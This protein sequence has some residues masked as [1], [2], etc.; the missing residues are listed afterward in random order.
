MLYTTPLGSTV[1]ALSDLLISLLIVAGGLAVAYLVH[2][3]FTWL[4]EKARTSDT[5]LDGLI[6]KILG[7]PL[8]VLVATFPVLYALKRIPAI[9]R[10][11]RR[12]E[13]AETALLVLIGTWLLSNLVQKIIH[14]YGM[15]FAQKTRTTVDERMIH[16]LDL[17]AVYVIWILGG[18]VALRTLGIKV[19][20]FLASMGIAG[21][22]VALAA[23]TVLS[24][25]L[26]GITLTA[27]PYLN[28]GDRIEVNEYIGDVIDI[29]LYKTTI[30]TRENKIVSI[31]NNVLVEE[32]V[33]NH[34]LPE[35]RTRLSL[36]FGVSYDADLNDLTDVVLNVLDEEDRIQADPEPEV[37]LTAFGDS[38]L[39]FEI[40]VWIDSPRGRRTV[41]DFV[42]R[43]LYHQFDEHGIEIPYPQRVVHQ[44]SRDA[45][46]E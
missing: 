10:R 39:Q 7:P 31:P 28:M 29:N 11:F 35:S 44:R 46:Q 24:N 30:R 27:D 14:H 40:Q 37:N 1:V 6:L 21:L 8:S 32:V 43:S 36:P 33:I 9:Q 15:P 2:R 18:L 4:G 19:T 16:I 20:A 41:R 25:M 42:Y 26:G 23:K 17:T 5:N 45:Q 13:G 34:E 22:A 38:A 12:W 3:L